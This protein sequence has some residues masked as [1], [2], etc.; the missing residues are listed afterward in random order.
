[1]SQQDFITPEKYPNYI[2][3]ERLIEEINSDIDSLSELDPL[4]ILDLMGIIGIE[5]AVGNAASD[6]YLGVLKEAAKV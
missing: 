1:M 3:A 6:E 4:L 5:F 2:F